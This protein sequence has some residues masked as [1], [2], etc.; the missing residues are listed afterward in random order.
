MTTIARKDAGDQIEVAVG[1]G[2]H[3]VTY[4]APVVDGA[5]RLYGHEWFP[6]H[7]GC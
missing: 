5:G 6:R 3:Q 2:T 7:A 1:L 4:T